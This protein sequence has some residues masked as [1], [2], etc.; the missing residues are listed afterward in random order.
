MAIAMAMLGLLLGVFVP[1]AYFLANWVATRL[2][3][4]NVLLHLVVVFACAGVLIVG[5]AEVIG[6]LFGPE[7]RRHAA[8]FFGAWAAGFVLAPLAAK[9]SLKKRH[10]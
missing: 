3:R 5:V 6:S 7:V 9:L 1:L 8:W 4:G 10:G 2:D